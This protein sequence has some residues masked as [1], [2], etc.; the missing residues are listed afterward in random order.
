VLREAPAR[1][2]A[3]LDY[4]FR[5]CLARNPAPR[6]RERLA[7]FLDEQIGLMKADPKAA[8]ALYPAAGPVDAA[9]GAAWVAVSRVLLNLDEFITR[10]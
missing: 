10:E 2:D 1:Q 9:E 8:A 5:L 4:A 6:E 3:R 7:K